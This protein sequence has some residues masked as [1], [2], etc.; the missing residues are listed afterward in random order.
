MK[1]EFQILAI[2]TAAVVIGMVT[3]G[4]QPVFAPRDC[5]G[6]IGN[7]Q[8]LTGEFVVNVAKAIGDP[9]LSQGPA[10]HLTEFRKLT[11]Q[12]E[13]DVIN[14][15]LVNPPE[16]DRIFGLLNS[17]DDGVERIFLGGS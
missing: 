12:F 14:A 11:A 13:R 5:A 6:C 16:P 10:P 4:I 3:V 7:F 1:T 8:K 15:A 9:N 17:Y 2:V